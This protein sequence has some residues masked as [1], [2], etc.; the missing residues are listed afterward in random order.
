MNK[1]HISVLGKIFFFANFSC[2]CNRG[3][4]LNDDGLACDSEYH[5]ISHC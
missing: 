5:P 2:E 1:K 3:Y 4:M